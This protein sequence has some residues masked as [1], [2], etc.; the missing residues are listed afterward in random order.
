MRYTIGRL[1]QFAGLV[2]L[3][4]AIVSELDGQV[5]LGRSLL[6][7]AG[8]ALVFYAGWLIQPRPPE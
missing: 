6:M 2:I 5:G 1:L 8:G 7:A 4:I 3:P